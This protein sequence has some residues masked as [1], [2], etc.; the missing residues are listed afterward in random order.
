M[1][2]TAFY[3][4]FCDI[5]QM[6]MKTRVVVIKHD[7]A[8]K[9]GG[10]ALAFDCGSGWGCDFGVT[11][12]PAETFPLEFIRKPACFFL[13]GAWMTL[14]RQRRRGQSTLGRKTE[15]EK[16][17]EFPSEANTWHRY[18]DRPKRALQAQAPQE[19]LAVRGRACETCGVVSQGWV[20]EYMGEGGA[21]TVKLRA[22][23]VTQTLTALCT[24]R[25]NMTQ[26]EPHPYQNSQSS[27]QSLLRTWNTSS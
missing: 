17:I 20:A 6:A 8:S 12:R 5:I 13:E 15:G 9:K 23:A 14:S 1:N 3:I 16:E 11:V 26:H 19:T 27:P 22:N 18:R 24:P 10:G 2:L 21:C 25:T 4:S 7:S